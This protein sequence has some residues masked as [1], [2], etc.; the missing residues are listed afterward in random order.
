MSLTTCCLQIATVDK[1]QG[2]QNDYILL[3]LVRTRAVGHIRDVRRLVV[4]LSR[5]RLGLYIFGRAELFANCYELRPAMK[6]LLARPQQ[7]HLHPSERVAVSPG[8]TVQRPCG[9]LGFAT[10]HVVCCL[11]SSVTA[12]MEAFKEASDTV[13]KHGCWLLYVHQ[14]V[15]KNILPGQT[16][17]VVASSHQHH[18]IDPQLAS[19]P[20]YADVVYSE[21]RHDRWPILQCWVQSCQRNLKTLGKPTIIPGLPELAGLVGQMAAQWEAR[22]Q[23]Q[24]T[25]MDTDA[26][27]PDDESDAAA[28]PETAS[29]TDAATTSEAPATTAEHQDATA[30]AAGTSRAAGSTASAVTQDRTDAQEEAKTSGADQGAAQSSEAVA[31]IS[32]VIEADEGPA[33]D[34]NADASLSDVV[35][36]AKASDA[37][38]GV[39]NEPDITHMDAVENRR[40]K[41]KK[42]TATS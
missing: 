30:A 23:Q 14:C 10:C 4:A 39:S 31:G 12:I 32:G 35:A 17:S 20:V 28:G 16:Q 18:V 8:H 1:Y 34:A 42:K 9:M 11:L 29:A 41:K 24:A 22:A 13:C 7:L 40:Q 26:E 3:S 2:Q 15:F 33:V 27:T 38:A 21:Q 5:A 6:Q 36:D 19:V 37:N 25:H